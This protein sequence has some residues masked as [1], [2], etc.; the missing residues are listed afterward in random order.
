M[1][2]RVRF[3]SGAIL[4]ISAAL[5]IYS[6]V[7][8]GGHGKTALGSDLGADYAGFYTAGWILNHRTV[9]DLYDRDAQ[10]RIHHELN[11][12]LKPEEQ[13]PYLY[14]P[15]VAVAFQPLAT[16]PYGWS[17]AIW[18]AFSLGFYVAGL[19]ILSQKVAWPRG[20]REM[21]FL[22]ALAFEP[23]AMECW[24]GGQVSSVGFFCFVAAWELDRR[25]LR[26]QSGMMLGLCLYKPTLLV[27]I[28]PVL[29]VVGR[30]QNLAGVA[31]TAALLV[32]FSLVAVGP[33]CCG[34]FV[35]KLLNFSRSATQT[36]GLELK[37]FKYIDL[38]AFTQLLL[39][40]TGTWQR[41]AFLG[42]AVPLFAAL[43]RQVWIIR[44]DQPA[45]WG[46][47]ILGTLVVN[48]YVGIYDGV[49]AVAGVVLLEASNIRRE[50][51]K[52]SIA[53]LAAVWVVPWITQ[54]IAK[55]LGVQLFTIVLV[56]IIIAN[57]RR[58]RGL[59]SP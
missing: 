51:S 32:M 25:G 2:S 50:R 45:I 39:G 53:M 59:A 7:S 12:H 4:V 1:K 38:N 41:V 52:W 16:L 29:L 26:P 6:F 34:A 15:F 18:L 5:L 13:L 37:T 54:P 44:G 31:V 58:S 20:D 30:W 55:T 56:S 42:L 22:A 21:F 48:L 40:G 3:I 14:P 47:A 35:Q 23:F 10:D 9:D 57:T 43:L 19:R 33:E 36:T 11:P 28:V 46:L 24:Q 27:V 8:S 49:L 17:F